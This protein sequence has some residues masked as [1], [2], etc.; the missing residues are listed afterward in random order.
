MVSATL[1]HAVPESGPLIRDSITRIASAI[2]K[3]CVLSAWIRTPILRSVPRGITIARARCRDHA[4]HS[5]VKDKHEDDAA[6]S[7]SLETLAHH[8][9]ETPRQRARGPSRRVR[10]ADLFNRSTAGGEQPPAGHRRHRQNHCRRHWRTRRPRAATRRNRPRRRRWPRI[11]C[12]GRRS[13]TRSSS[14]NRP[15][16]TVAAAEADRKAI[17]AQHREALN[18]KKKL[19]AALKNSQQETEELAV[20]RLEL[21]RRL[22][23]VTAAKGRSGNAISAA[24][25]REPE[26]HRRAVAD[27][28]RAT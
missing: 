22:K 16:P 9:L 24:R 3:P 8:I 1:W 27:A 18:E 26:T 28:A 7:V 25:A 21:Q 4:D 23:D 12:S 2:S 15:R 5:A 14:L 20:E 13:T 10:P 19:A 17:A 11:T 6:I